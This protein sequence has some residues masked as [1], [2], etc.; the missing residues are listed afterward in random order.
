MK[1]K[2]LASMLVSATVLGIFAAGGTVLAGQKDSYDT[3]VGI[4]FSD[5]E[6]GK[7][8]GD[9]EIKWAPIKLDF[10]KANSTNKLSFD[11]KSGLK[12]YVVV[13]DERTP[14]VANKWELN[15]KLGALTS[16]ATPL[17]G[18]ELKFDSTKQGYQGTV[19]PEDGGS[20]I[21]PTGSATVE[22][23]NFTLA[24]GASATTVMKDGTGAG[25][26]K[27][28]SALEMSNIKI[29]APANAGEAGKQYSG[30]LTW[31]LDDTI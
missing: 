28:M 1:K 17:T 6:P 9:L 8:P 5:H 24:Q 31:S 29:E 14:N 30:T 13:S 2:L 27:G 22:G 16:G 12:K 19:G 11:E 21:A 26:Y 20:V 10:G 7:T 3:G 18:A 25:T 4:G 23:L 15:V